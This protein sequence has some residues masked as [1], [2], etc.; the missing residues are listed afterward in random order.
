MRYALLVS[1]NA[2]RHVSNASD[3][4]YENRT[5]APTLLVE[6]FRRSV[7]LITTRPRAGSRFRGRTD[8]EIRPVL[9]EKTRYYLYYRVDEAQEVVE[10]LALWHQS[11]GSEP[12]F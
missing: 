8:V 3:W 9:L 6:E 10:V 5:A 7:E 12:E 2:E 11:R 1:R 4:W